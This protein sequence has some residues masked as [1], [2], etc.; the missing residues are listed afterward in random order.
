MNSSLHHSDTVNDHLSLNLL[1]NAIEDLETRYEP[2]PPES[3]AEG[4]PETSS[5]DPSQFE[6]EIVVPRGRCPLESL[7]PEL[8]SHIVSFLDVRAAS[9]LR[10]TNRKVCELASRGSFNRRFIHNRSI[11]LTTYD[12]ERFVEATR[13]PGLPSQIQHC[14][15]NDVMYPNRQL[16]RQELT[17]LLD[18]PKEQHL[19]TQAFRNLLEN[20]EYHGLISLSFGVA[21]TDDGWRQQNTKFRS[22]KTVWHAA[23]RSFK[24]T[25]AAL[26]ES[27][28]LVR[29]INLFQHLKGCSLQVHSL[30]HFTRELAAGDN[31]ILLKKLSLSLSAPLKLPSRSMIGAE[32]NVPLVFDIGYHSQAWYSLNALQSIL[33]W[34]KFMP[35]LEELDVHWYDI[36]R[37]NTYP[38]TT[39][40]S[41]PLSH[42]DLARCLTL[43]LA[44]VEGLPH[45]KKCTLKG[46]FASEYGL[47]G[48]L[49]SVNPAT[50]TL[51]D[52]HLEMGTYRGIFAYLTDEKCPITKYCLDDLYEGSNGPWSKLV[53]FEV[54]GTPKFPYLQNNGGRPSTLERGGGATKV[55]IYYYVQHKMDLGSWEY[56]VWQRE[57]KIMYGPLEGGKYDFV[58]LNKAD[59]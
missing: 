28:L 35:R 37:Y 4:Y 29:H 41:V 10:L 2:L 26:E 25:M 1:S 5:R 32:G 57:K 56:G 9:Y 53:H 7:P 55:A 42:P 45:L 31:F 23:A 52:V 15:I 47:L 8:V 17:T 44:K 43:S 21:I 34:M 51:A 38:P 16:R 12:L 58:E 50:L 3:E 54:P 11:M 19:L 22:W 27:G 49:R 39:A 24:M 40:L 6:Q 14:T 46:I 30:V 36:N 33:L 20:S 13:K 48:F 18:S 59:E